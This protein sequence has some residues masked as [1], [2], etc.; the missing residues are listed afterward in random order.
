M[1]A[2]EKTKIR[3]HAQLREKHPPLKG[4]RV[5]VTRTR[6]QAGTLSAM[7]RRQGATVIEVP[8]IEIRPPRSWLQLDQ[9]LRGHET[10]DWL[11][12]TSVNGVEALAQ[13]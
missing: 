10:F 12:L 2:K 9:S 1:S 13:R 4:L 7:L 5:L 8:T 3:S 11:I 6:K